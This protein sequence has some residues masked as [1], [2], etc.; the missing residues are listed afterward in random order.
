[1]AQNHVDL[2][3][4][5]E[6]PNNLDMPRLE[7]TVLSLRY[8]SWSMRPWLALTH[9][10]ANFSTATV[11]LAHMQKQADFSAGTIDM[12]KIAPTPL[13][14]RRAL[15]SVHGLFPALRV[16]GVPIHE[17][18]AICEY[19]AEAF[20]DAGLWPDDTLDRA[21]ARAISC[22]MVGGFANMRAEL[23]CHLFGR[24]PGF[25]PS[26]G[27][28]SDI[29]RVFELWSECLERSDGPFLFGHFGIADAMYFPVLT[30]LRTYGIPLTDKIG[31][32]ARA[33]DDLP[34]VRKLLE[35][36]RSGPRTV[37][38]DDYLR[39]LGGDPDAAL[40]AG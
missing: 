2:V 32:Y 10:G 39:V 6:K 25:T 31:D 3:M 17:S 24:V 29:S 5:N 23:A 15:G 11:E 14:D 38:Y 8:S 30:R 28:Q 27:T 35:V 16:D 36:A 9:A 7:L 37:I 1:M 19:A 12:S 22:E 34:A 18:L 26:A 13:A 40:P 4:H 21:Q 33:L 20:P